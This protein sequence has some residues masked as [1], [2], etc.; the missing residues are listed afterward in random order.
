LVT[1]KDASDD[2][3]KKMQNILDAAGVAN[4][5]KGDIVSSNC[6][7][8]QTYNGTVEEYV[9]DYGKHYKALDGPDD[10]SAAPSNLV[11]FALQIIAIFAFVI[12]V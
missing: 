7:N 10:T 6:V 8:M 5:K 9:G 2:K 12:L 3:V 4:L 11:S 1:N